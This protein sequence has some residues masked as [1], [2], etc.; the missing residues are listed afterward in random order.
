MILRR[1]IAHFR[2]QEW[3]A[4]GLDF[5]IVVVGI[6]IAFQITAWNDARRDAIRERQYLARIAAELDE[7]ISDIEHAISR[8]KER[9]AYG[10]FLIR[11]I[12]DP[13]LVRDDPGRFMKAIA[14]AGYTLSPDI[15]SQTFDEIKSVGDLS[16]LR[17]EKLRFDLMEFY[18]TIHGEGQWNYIRELRQTEYIKRSAGILTYEQLARISG[19]DDIPPAR[20]EDAVAAHARMLERPAFVEWLPIMTDRTDD[21]VIYADWLHAAK[22]LRVRIGGVRGVVA[23]NGL[24]GAP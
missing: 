10:E 19:S 6:L 24:K 9:T 14:F 17:D 13:G 7:S 4:I 15:R 3:T 20:V 2:K 23:A 8:T 21:G 12:D 1:V 18:T 5:L 22:E 11:S 16:L